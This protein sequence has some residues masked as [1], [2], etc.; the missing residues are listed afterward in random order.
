MAQSA[1]KHSSAITDAIVRLISRASDPRGL[2]T[3]DV[4]PRVQSALEKYLLKDNSAAERWEIGTFVDELRADDLCLI[5]ACERGDEKAWEDLVANFDSTV[6][7]AAR[8][9]SPTQLVPARAMPA[10]WMG[11]RDRASPPGCSPV[12]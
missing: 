11:P 3:D 12:E 7:S 4:R 5:L 1:E 8:K 10:T 2:S 9:I 6:K